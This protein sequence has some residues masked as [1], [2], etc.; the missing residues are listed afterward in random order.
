MARA[1]RAG[2]ARRAEIR[3]WEWVLAEEQAQGTTSGRLRR[4]PCRLVPVA[5]AC[6]LAPGWLSWRAAVWSYPATVI[7]LV[8]VLVN[9]PRG[10]GA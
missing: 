4:V 7:K 8:R 5:A 9:L 1:E 6:R 3:H 2:A 10:P